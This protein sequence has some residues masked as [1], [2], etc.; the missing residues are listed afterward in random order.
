M[1]AFQR[2]NNILLSSLKV[3]K[4][5]PILKLMKFTKPLATALSVSI[6]TILYGAAY[7]WT[8]AVVIM[9]LLFVHEMGH[10]AALRYLGKPA[11]G[12]V[13]IP[14]IG[15]AI[16]A[17]DVGS[18]EEESLMAICGPAVGAASVVVAMILYFATQHPLFAVAAYVGVLLNL[19]NMIPISPL[20]GGR[21]VQVA[22]PGFIYLGVSVLIAFSLI[23]A[24]PMIL[25][26]WI[27]ILDN[28]KMPRWVR[29]M[30][31]GVLWL[32]MIL[33][34]LAGYSTQKVWIDVIDCAVGTLVVLTLYFIDLNNDN[35]GEAPRA[36]PALRRR[37]AWL[38]AW[39]ALSTA[40]AAT[41]W[42]IGVAVLPTL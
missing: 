27:L 12:P 7:G 31:G 3:S 40:L 38:L 9:V 10:V 30:L 13:F 33:L 34:M 6:S 36:Y 41:G 22:G 2:I 42:L 25:L 11:P 29:P 18:R 35:G 23:I 15:A 16:F 32:V 1:S 39:S 5:L 4:L 17:K 14:F 26:I 20:D 8:F 37:L 19:F 24:Q 28:F 21:V